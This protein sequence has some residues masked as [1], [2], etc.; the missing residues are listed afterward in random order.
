MVTF[1]LSVIG[2]LNPLP[3]QAGLT[4]EQLKIVLQQHRELYPWRVKQ[5]LAWAAQ[6]SPGQHW[7][8]S[9]DLQE[10]DQADIYLTCN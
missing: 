2:Y 7:Q 8:T 5:A 4:F 1:T 6:A 10:S 9:T 3:K